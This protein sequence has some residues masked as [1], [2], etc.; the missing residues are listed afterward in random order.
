MVKISG[1]EALKMN[2][3]TG[4]VCLRWGLGGAGRG[5]FNKRH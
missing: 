1:S 2:E 4:V 3:E 5:R